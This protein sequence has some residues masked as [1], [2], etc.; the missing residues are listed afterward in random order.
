MRKRRLI[1][2][3]QQLRREA[4]FTQVQLAERLGV[5]QSY[6]SKYEA[7]ERRLD[8]LELE[9]I[10]GVLGISLKRLVARYLES[11]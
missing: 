11:R 6:V 1:K 5:S 3:L 8:L 10:C 4:G 9:D 2:L 7:G